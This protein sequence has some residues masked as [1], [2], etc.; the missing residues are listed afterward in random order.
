MKAINIVFKCLNDFLFPSQCFS[1]GKPGA[2]VCNVCIKGYKPAELRC[3]SCLKRNPFG[4]YCCSR[5]TTRPSR[6]LARFAFHKEVRKLIHGF[7]YEDQTALTGVF[8]DE[9]I[10]TIKKIPRYKMHS[11]AF[12]PLSNSRM[13]HRGYNQAKLLAEAI[14]A[15]L[16]MPLTD[17]I[18]R[19]DAPLSQVEA[20]DPVAR[21]RN[22]RGVFKVRK[23]CILPKKVILVDDVIT[24]GATVEEATKVLKKCGVG[25]VIVV[26]LA[27]A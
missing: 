10:K 3:L 16:K 19:V 18:V 1:C 4:V 26:A 5:Q 6:V 11:L 24:T 13:R 15:K 9:L 7:K 17:L 20:K 23:D 8:A 27:L 22:I 21:R 14:A 12:I 25:E 2:A